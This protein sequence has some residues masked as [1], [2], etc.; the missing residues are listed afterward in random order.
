MK[1]H[2]YLIPA[3][4]LFAFALPLACSDGGD[5]TPTTPTG[6]SPTSC[7]TAIEQAWNAQN[8][9][10]FKR[11]LDANF[12][13][14]FNA[15]DVGATVNGYTIPASWTYAQ[16]CDA[17]FYMLEYAVSVNLDVAAGAIGTPSDADTNWQAE[18]VPLTLTAMLTESAGYRTG[19]CCDFSFAR[20][21]EDGQYN[22]Y[23]KSWRDNTSAGE[24][25]G[26][27]TVEPSSLG[28]ILAI[29]YGGE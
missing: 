14:Y 6:T 9:G 11:Y 18:R 8:Y 16:M 3:A 17:C 4:I 22:W 25:G 13:F 5:T 12:K 2:R 24:A 23:L 10:I 28:R 7:M 21:E 27:P 26:T 1:F 29:C 15:A 20:R 19:G